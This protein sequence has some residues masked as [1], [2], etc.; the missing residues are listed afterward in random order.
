MPVGGSENTESALAVPRSRYLS[1]ETR[2]PVRRASRTRRPLIQW[3]RA[4]AVSPRASP[5]L[6]CFRPRLL[7][8]KP[9]FSSSTI[10]TPWLT[11]YPLNSLL[12]SVVTLKL[13]VSASAVLARGRS[14]LLRCNGAP[15]AS[16]I[17]AHSFRESAHLERYRREQF[18]V[19]TESQISCLD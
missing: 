16:A 5:A 13:S 15:P 6:H 17:C 9:C 19:N 1:R 11:A 2:T 8:S 12:N 10:V 7:S 4:P 14:L 3:L 18:S